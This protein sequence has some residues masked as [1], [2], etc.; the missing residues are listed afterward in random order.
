MIAQT[1]PKSPPASRNGA[2]L[3]REHDRELDPE[4]LRAAYPPNEEPM[5]D[6]ARL[7]YYWLDMLWP[8]FEFFGKLPNVF[9]NGDVFIYYRVNG[10]AKMVAP[11]LMISFDVDPERI[12]DCGSY[13]MWAVGKPPEFVM[14]IGSDS[15]AARDLADKLEIYARIGADEYWLFDPPDGARYKF[16][17]KG[18]RLANGV[19]EEI[20]MEIGEDSGVRGYSAALNLRL[21]WEGGAIHFAD[22]ETGEYLKNQKETI[23]DRDAQRAARIAAEAQRDA[24][25]E[26]IA[27]RDAAIAGRDAAI[28]DR[29]AEIERLRA[30][31]G[32]EEQT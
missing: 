14:E 5:A 15:T 32:D 31:L 2:T 28:A 17:L 16:I 29:D 22:P 18:F 24:A 6:P 13:H 12:R 21:C 9:I 30:M 27:D 8:L 19:Y 20:P 4:Y 26:T 10:V 3:Q 11:D 25:L 7:L 1:V 23:A